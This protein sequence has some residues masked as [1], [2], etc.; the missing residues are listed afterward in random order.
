MQTYSPAKLGQKVLECKLSHARCIVDATAGNGRDTLFLAKNSNE[1]AKIWAF[2]IQE[3]A[4][5]S[6]KK[7][8]DDAGYQQKVVFILDS[9]V[10]V[11]KYVRETVDIAMFNLGYLPR[12]NH[13][14][15]TNFNST[16]EAVQHILEILSVGGIV[17]II[18]YPGHRQGEEE[19]HALE[20]F[21]RQLEPTFYTVGCWNLINHSPKAPV[22]YVIEKARSEVREGITSR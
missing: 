14:I 3:E 15:T 22:L 1:Q 4:I 20:L 2:D 16:L 21:L 5:S 11:E 13:S 7:L 17:T 10:N 12:G 8:L 18:A 19:Y 9:H 6:A